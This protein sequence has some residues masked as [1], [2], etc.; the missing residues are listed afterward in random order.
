MFIC[1]IHR[2]VNVSTHCMK[3]IL[4]VL[5]ICFLSSVY[6]QKII[7]YDKRY[8]FHVRHN[9]FFFDT[10]GEP[11]S[12]FEFTTDNGNIS[13]HNSSIYYKPQRAGKSVII[14]YKKE[15]NGKVFFDSLLIDV[16]KNDLGQASILLKM[17]GQLSKEE[18]L[19]FGGVMT[20]I[21]TT[22]D[23]LDPISAKSFTFILTKE[24]GDNI[25][26][27]NVGNLFN[28]KIKYIIHGS[29]PGDRITITNIKSV[30]PDNS[31]I[32]VPPIE[33]TIK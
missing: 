11:Y 29:E 10:K 7:P 22:E 15:N 16:K 12:S 31:L 9:H 6:S 30:G 8:E 13:C 27:N 32:R 18:L 33:F 23:H 20:Q 3:L 14:I 5:S 19:A 1:N 28:E 24:N 2:R 17:G 25:C 21:Q 4:T 26:A